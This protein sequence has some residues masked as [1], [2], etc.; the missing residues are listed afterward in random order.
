MATIVNKKILPSL[1]VL[2][3][4]GRREVDEKLCPEN[5]LPEAS[6]EMR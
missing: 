2:G 5:S 3:C 6:V 1:S 4:R